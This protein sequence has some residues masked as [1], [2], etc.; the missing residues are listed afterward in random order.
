MLL[1]VSFRGYFGRSILLVANR[2]GI[3]GT[4]EVVPIAEALEGTSRAR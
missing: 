2:N 1:S 3:I 4:D